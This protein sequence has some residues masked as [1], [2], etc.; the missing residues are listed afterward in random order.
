MAY[1]SVHCAMASERHLG[2]NHIRT[3]Q[4]HP[5]G[6]CS[7]NRARR[8]SWRWRSTLILLRTVIQRTGWSTSAEK[9]T[10]VFIL[11][12]DGRQQCPGSQ[13]PGS[14]NR[15]ALVLLHCVD[16]EVVFVFVCVFSYLIFLAG[17]FIIYLHSCF[18]DSIPRLRNFPSDYSDSIPLPIDY[19]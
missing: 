8:F 19:S 4:P 2:G 18:Y 14:I 9:W 5:S 7:P 13:C 17:M 11:Y 1:F 12:T 10:L 15:R 6:R 16:S 3:L